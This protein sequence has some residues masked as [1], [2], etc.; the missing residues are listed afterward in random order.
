VIASLRE[1]S[2]F[3]GL[4]I[5]DT[6]PVS[7][8]DDAHVPSIR[9]APP[10]F[11]VEA[12]T[13]GG[14]IFLDELTTAPPAVQAALLRAVVDVA[15]G[16]LEL[17]PERVTLVA[18]ANPPEEAAGGW[19]LAPPL[20]NRFVHHT[21]T[22]VAQDWVE[23]FPGYWG[24]APR[25]RF[26]RGQLDGATWGK[27]R[28]TIAAFIRVRPNLLFQVPRDAGSRGQAWPSPRTWE[29]C[30]RLLA[31]VEQAGGKPVDAL[32]LLAG[33]VGE[34]A[35]LELRTW[36]A[37]LDLPD[38]ESL[39]ADPNAYRHPERGDQAYAILSSVSQ[40]AIEN[41]TPDRWRAAWQVLARA[42]Q[43]GGA[44]VAASAARNLARSRTSDLETPVRELRH[45]FPILEAAGLLQP[46]PAAA[47]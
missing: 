46:A 4:P 40:A 26:G 19:D 35:A 12:A 42:A 7:A 39:L 29:Y 2:D 27:A 32:G 28:A 11:A 13:H 17:D 37:E 30:S 3:A 34:G 20:A 6:L 16:D 22:L 9:F 38:P 45:F 1:P 14:V 43:A 33:S 24:A 8:A 36:L 41:L 5:V 18:A 15:F 23:A 25:L 10:R 21:H 47:A 44:D 31:S